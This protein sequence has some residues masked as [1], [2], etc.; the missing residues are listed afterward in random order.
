MSPA[1]SRRYQVFVSSTY[2][3]LIEERRHVI[4]ALLETRCIPCGMELFPASTEEKWAV[5]KRLID[6]CDYFITIIAGMYGSSPTADGTSFTEMEFDYALQRGMKPIGFFHA[7]I[8]SLPSAKVERSDA[9]RQKLE[10]FTRRVREGM[11]AKWLSAAELGSAVKSAMINAFE[12]DPKPGWM[13]AKTLPGAAE[14]SEIRQIVRG[15]AQRASAAAGVIG[16]E[17]LKIPVVDALQ[18][19]RKEKVT[20]QGIINCPLSEA[21]AAISIKFDVPKPAG[22]LNKMFLRKIAP[23]I[24]NMNAVDPHVGRPLIRWE[25]AKGFFD[26]VLKTFMAKGLLRQVLPPKH[27]RSRKSLYWELTSSGRRERA[28][29]EALL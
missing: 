13:K 26:R 17:V 23:L 16:Q 18:L 29:L 4:Q 6:D 1:L 11:C 10:G 22:V 28:R 3:D 7:D 5:I 21:F 12:H 9:K 20:N 27:L 2:E 19:Q 24:E 25:I 14:L 15:R 8:G